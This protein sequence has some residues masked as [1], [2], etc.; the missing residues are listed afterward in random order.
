MTLVSFLY[1]RE[2]LIFFLCFFYPSLSTLISRKI[3][4]ME[5]IRPEKHCLSPVGFC[6]NTS[7]NI[8]NQ[9]LYLAKQVKYTLATFV[10]SCNL[11]CLVVCCEDTTSSLQNG[12]VCKYEYTDICLEHLDTSQL[13][14]HLIIKLTVD[15]DLLK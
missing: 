5:K 6:K 4:L 14:I 1:P 10:G 2:K 9:N 7:Q 13:L 15:S 8:N 12:A 11:R 3:S